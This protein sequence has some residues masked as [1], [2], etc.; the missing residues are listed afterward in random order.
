METVA[1]PTDTDNDG[2]A[3]FLDED[4]DNDGIPDT[5]EGT[6]DTDADG[7]RNALE[8]DSDQDGIDDVIG[9]TPNSVDYPACLLDGG[10]STTTGP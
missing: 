9:C 10:G 3:D 4:S 8:T 5:V 2:T 7:I 6:T 1:S